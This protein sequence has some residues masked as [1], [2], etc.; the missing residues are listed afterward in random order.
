MPTPTASLIMVN[1]DCAAPAPLARFYA[2]LLGWEVTHSQDEYA[3]V[4]DG[5]TSLGF[6]RVEDFKAPPWPDDTSDKRF[7]LDFYVDDV[8]QAVAFC[9][10]RGGT[11]PD[12]QPGE[13][14]WRVLLDPDGHPFCLCPRPA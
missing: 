8:D 1:I 11:V 13:G 4:S 14:R 3:M 2:D 9:E 6:G 12:F 5:S 7:H 10:K